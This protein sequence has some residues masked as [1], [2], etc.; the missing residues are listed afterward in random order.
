MT[1]AAPSTAVRSQGKIRS[2]LGWLLIAVLVIA[3]ALAIGSIAISAPDSRGSLDP[4]SA[5]DSGAAALAELLRDQGV[6]ITVARTRAEASAAIEDGATLAMRD[7]FSLSDDAVEDLIA[8]AD[9]VV[10]LS[11]ASRLLRLLDLGENAVASSAQQLTSECALPEFA[12]VGSIRPDRFFAPADDVT[13]CYVDGDNGAAALLAADRGDRR[14]LLIEGDSLFSNAHL[15][16]MGNA[17]L[18]LALLGQ[19]ER[20]VWYVPSF[21]DSDIEAESTDTLATLT[22]SW[23]TPAILLLMLAGVVVSI[24]RGQRFGPLV[25]ETLPVTVRASETMLGRARLTAKAADAAHAAEALRDGSL[26]RLAK[27]MSLDARSTPTDVA[28]AAADRLRIPRGSLQQLLSGPLPETDS[29]L[30][31]T[32]RHLAELEAAV[33]SAVHVERNTP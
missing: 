33:E 13:G 22:P 31:D 3:F 10:F 7:P 18:G 12:N 11:S 30:I 19:S 5:K 16:E 20:L 9:R 8:P 17:A 24:A 29:D 4:E 23:V 27:R 1:L 32:A 2:A 6:D 15:A 25:A 28:D 14:T 26:R 21:E